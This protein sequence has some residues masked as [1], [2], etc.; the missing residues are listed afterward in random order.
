[1][2]RFLVLLAIFFAGGLSLLVGFAMALDAAERGSL[3][4]VGSSDA[5]PR[6]AA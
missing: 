2:T 4:E 6:D 5:I 3:G 1:M